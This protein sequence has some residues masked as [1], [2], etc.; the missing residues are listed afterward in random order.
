MM[1]CVAMSST[2]QSLITTETIPPR[3]DVK[4]W[5]WKLDWDDKYLGLQ[6]PIKIATADSIV[7]DP[8][9]YVL[10]YRIDGETV[11]SE[12]VHIPHEWLSFHKVIYLE[13][14][15]L[16]DI[17]FWEAHKNDPYIEF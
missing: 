1:L 13:L 12:A 9:D 5:I 15:R 14:P 17:I 16:T 2:A 10:D 4:L 7:L 8:A 3:T 11:H 6:Q